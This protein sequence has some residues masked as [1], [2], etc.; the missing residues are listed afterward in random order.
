MESLTG[1]CSPGCGGIGLKHLASLMVVALLLS[2]LS[3]PASG[4]VHSEEGPTGCAANRENWTIGLVHCTSEASVD[5]VLFSPIPSNTTYLIDQEGRMINAWT[6]PGA[7]RPALSAYLLPDGSLLRSSNI[8]TEAVGNFTGGGIGGN[9]ERI[10]WNGTLLWSWNYTSE[11]SILHHDIEP[12]PNG[13]ILA[14]AWEDIPEDDAVAAGRNPAIVSDSPNGGNNVWPDKV[15]EI[16]PVGSDDA[17]IVWT[18]RAWDHLVQDHNASL[19]NY[20]AIAD[21][22][23]RLNV[24]HMGGTGDQQGRADW[25]HCNGLD[26]HPVLDQIALSCRSMNEIYIIDHS[27]TTEEAATDAGGNAGHGGDFLYRW[28]NPQVYGQ[29]TGDDQR[30]FAQHDVQWVVDGHPEAGGLSVFNNGNGRAVPFSSVDI[31]QP[32]LDNGTYDIN[33]SG[34]FGPAEPAWTWD[35]GESMYSGSIS[36]AQALPNGHMLVTHG[37]VGTL[38]EVDETG[39]IVWTYIDPVGRTGPH[40]QGEPVPPGN[41]AGTTLNAVFK[42]IHYDRSYL[43]GTGMD[44][45]PQGYIEGWVDDCPTVEAWGLDVD[46]DG[47]VDDGDAD[48]VPDHEDRCLAGDDSVDNDTDGVPDACDTLVDSDGDGVADADD[49]CDGHDDAVDVDN[50]G[51]PDACDDLLDNDG[52]GIDNTNDRCN[53]HDDGVDL[54]GDNTPDGCDDL[55]DRDMDG[56]ADVDDACPAHDDRVDTDGDG[57]ADGCD[58]TPAGNQT[59]GVEPSNNTNEPTSSTETD[60]SSGTLALAPGFAVGTVLALGLAAILVWRRSRSAQGR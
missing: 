52:D 36:G 14:I 4:E 6:S 35:I 12:M 17:N 51:T 26:Y 9:I 22:P 13:N 44:L 1:T 55:I 40:T 19:P 20:G 2:G 60:P 56:V 42:A 5:Y 8:G 16:E 48:G 18:W 50:D 39:N 11:T 27:T 59:L 15:I 23:R 29:G 34:A 38:Y 47:C 33:A 46:G 54:D 43:E 58:E 32:V 25:M 37:T 41:R 28:G 10:A 3:L 7:Y 24:N 31:I 30:L 49:R 21:H 57:V 53:G 45:A